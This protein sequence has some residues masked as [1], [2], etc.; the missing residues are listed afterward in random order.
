MTA[1]PRGKGKGVTPRPRPDDG[2]WSDDWNTQEADIAPAR[3]LGPILFDPCWNVS[4]ITMPRVACWPQSQ[5]PQNRDGL[6]V[7]W[8]E[9]C[10]LATI[11]D[12]VEHGIV[13]VQP[14]FSELARWLTKSAE[15]AR[16]VTDMGHAIVA[17][18]PG[19]IEQNCVVD[20][21]HSTQLHAHR[22]GRAKYD[23]PD[24]RK[25]STASFPS[26]MFIWCT[27]LA[28]VLMARRIARHGWWCA[29]AL[30]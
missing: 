19:R 16:A 22:I 5:L 29:E 9:Y 18:V 17:H 28:P 3:E 2:A 27:W 13:F 20:I 12:P 30:S 8:S 25:A 26:T 23:H 4:A 15:E 1:R 10:R 24:G 6:A 7:S 21:V 14:P 11:M